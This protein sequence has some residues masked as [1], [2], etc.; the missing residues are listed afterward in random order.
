MN[1]V[2]FSCTSLNLH[3]DEAQN[4]EGTSYPVVGLDKKYHSDP[5]AMK[6]LILKKMEELPSD[7]DTILVSM[8]LCGGSW[9]GIEAKHRIVI[10]KVDDCITLLLHKD[11]EWAFNLKEYGH[12][13]LRDSINDL[14]S[15]V[16]LRDELM[17]EYGAD[18]ADI[19]MQEW[20]STYSNVDII[21]T[22]IYDCHSD[23]YMKEAAENAELVSCELNHRKGSN[24]LLEKL[25]SGKW[26]HQFLVVEKED[27]SSAVARID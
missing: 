2:I 11:E 18:Q 14:F 25:V 5:A 13:Y 19:I 22:G 27:E 12:F 6:E 8:G 9:S 7:V 16:K 10:P 23:E 4:K 3:I 20:F 24:I 26:D 15:L 1:A 17:E 21:D